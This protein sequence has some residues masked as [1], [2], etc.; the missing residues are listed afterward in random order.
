VSIPDTSINSMY[1]CGSR[2][3]ASTSKFSATSIGG[4]PV[5]NGTGYVVGV[6]AYDEVL[7]LGG[8]SPLEC[9]EPLPVDSFYK[10]YCRDGGSACP[11]CGSCNV[12]ENTDPV[13]PALGAAALAA[14][15]GLSR[16]SPRRRRRA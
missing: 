16:R 1:V 5:E 9:A 15:F 4:M 7:N 14:A 2:V 13:W 8:M 6:V 12:G 3:P 11:G 10:V